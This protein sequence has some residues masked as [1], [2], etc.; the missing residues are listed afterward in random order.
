[1]GFL[2]AVVWSWTHNSCDEGK[3]WR[4]GGCGYPLGTG[5]GPGPGHKGPP[6]NTVLHKGDTGS[7][8]SFGSGYKHSPRTQ[9]TRSQSLRSSSRCL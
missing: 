6:G 4:S 5:M 1:M 3:Q 2:P 7:D 9:S 8:L